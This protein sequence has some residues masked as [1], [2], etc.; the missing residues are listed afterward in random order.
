MHHLNSLSRSVA[1]VS[2]I[3]VLALAAGC[4]KPVDTGAA[5]AGQAAVQ[6]DTAAQAKTASKLGDLSS[7]RAIASDVNDIVDKGDLPAAMTRIKALE[8]A[9]D[10]A[11]AGLKPRAAT[12]WHVLDKAI[13]H[14]LKA[15]RAD[16]ANLADCKKT[17]ADLLSTFDSLQ[18]KA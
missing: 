17:L 5:G 14:A 8:V 3:A 6:L 2:A 9:W 4:S 18:A 13:D 11:E 16:P 12:D 10:S 15:L 1:A 7:F